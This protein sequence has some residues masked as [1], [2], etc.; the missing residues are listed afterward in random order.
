MRKPVFPRS[1]DPTMQSLFN[2][3]NETRSALAAAYARFDYT[4]QSELIDSCIYELGA[5]E[6]RYSYLLRC[7]K[8]HGAKAAHATLSEGTKQWV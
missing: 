5:I 6:A 2:E 3:L 1:A 4:T 7:V 8:E